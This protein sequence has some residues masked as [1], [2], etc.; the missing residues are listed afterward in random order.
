MGSDHSPDALLD[1]LRGFSPPKGVEF[2]AIG[3]PEFKKRSPVPF[4]EAADFISMDENPL[5]VLRKK[6]QASMFIGLRLLKQKKINAF[7]SSGNTGAL[8]IGAKTILTCLPHILRP[9]FLALMPTKKQPVA[10][11]DLGANVQC[12]AIHLMQFAMM[13]SAY[14]TSRNIHSGQGTKLPRI[15]ILN[16]GSESMKGTSELRLAYHTLQTLPNAPFQFCGNIEGKSVFD[17][18]V[19]AL[20]TDGFIGN[21]FLKTAEGI[22]SLLLDQITSKLPKEALNMLGGPFLDLQKRLHYAEYPGALLVGVKGI[23]IKCH[24]YATPQAFI[25]GI[26]EAIHLSNENF[27][28]TFSS[29]LQRSSLKN[30]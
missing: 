9:A 29:L 12:K 3:L 18:D 5:T 17:G 4:H 24:G 14:L 8:V 19:D 13:G 6:Q 25:N 21:I 15:G 28:E 2:L 11:L 30:V 22:A 1:A 23:V 16:I 26:L 20:I 27:M 7:V 10:V